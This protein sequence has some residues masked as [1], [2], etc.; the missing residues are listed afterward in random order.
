MLH[1][2]PW[3]PSASLGYK[4]LYQ[5][6]KFSGN[7]MD[8]NPFSSLVLMTWSPMEDVVVVDVSFFRDDDDDE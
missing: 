2:K 4:K 3:P 7:L 5:S 1:P 8:D 6:V